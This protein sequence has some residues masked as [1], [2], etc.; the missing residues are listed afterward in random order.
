M[1]DSKLVG[2]SGADTKIAALW[3]NQR[4]LPRAWTTA[5]SGLLASIVTF[6]VDL[7]EYTL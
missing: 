7:F 5:I 4:D 3:R 2:P 1:K 6:I